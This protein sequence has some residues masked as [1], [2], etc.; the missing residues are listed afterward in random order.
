MVLKILICVCS[1]AVLLQACKS[2]EPSEAIVAFDNSLSEAYPETRKDSVTDDYFGT[3]IADPY[4]WLEDDHSEETGDWVKRQNAVTQNYL[5]KIPFR[6][7]V[8]SRVEELFNYEKSGTP[9]K[10]S[11]RYYYFRNDGLQ[12]QDVLY[13]KEQLDAEPKLVIDPNKFSEDG[14]SSMSNYSFSKDGKYL[15]FQLS[16]GG[17]DWNEI[18]VLDL[19]TNQYLS[20]TIRWVKFSSISWVENGFYYSRFPEPKAE[21]K[22]SQKNENHSVYFHKLG[23]VQDKDKLVFVD[24]KN[25]QRTAFCSVTE[26]QRILI[27]TP[28]QSTSGNEL[29]IR[30]LDKP[31]SKLKFL[32]NGFDSD[33]NVI[34]NKGNVLYVHT[35]ASADNWR[36][37]AIDLD[38]PSKE[39]WKDLVPE[40]EDVLKSVDFIGGKF[41]CTYIHNAASKAKIFDEGGS[42]V[43]ELS[44]PELGTLG[45][46]TGEQDDDE[47]F[48]SFSSFVR[49]TS[50]YRLD[51]NTYNSELVFAPV[52]KNY[53]PD[54]YTTDQ[55]W[56]YSK[57]RTKV[58]MFITYKRT[59]KLDQGNAPTLLYAYGGFNISIMPSFSS[60]RLILLEQGGIFAVPNIRGG[61]EFGKD[62][63]KAGT[64]EQKQNVFD[65]FISAAEFLVKQKYTSHDRLALE[66][67]S[68]G[69]L[70]VGA[71]ITQRPDLCRVAFPRVGV[72]DMLRYHKFTIGWAW[73]TDYGTSE[74][75]EGFDYLIRYSPLHNTRPADYPATMIATADH[76]DRVV[77]AHSFKFGAALQAAQQSSKPVLLR[78]D[79]SAGHGAGKST[80]MRIDETADLSC[81]MLFNMNIDPK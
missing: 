29:A 46:F 75:K 36:L 5:N 65:D 41:I 57:D 39:Q 27:V 1:I 28:R 56:Y 76:D 26:D 55:V 15:G 58:P 48:Y 47:A 78:I 24:Q 11:K 10:K 23:D 51:M 34:G 6:A 12:N 40:S 68:N 37:I 54:E 31:D 45:G 33:Y 44:L 72:L 18:M 4:R 9:V 22:L 60:A 2:N 77:P 7:K 30:Y 49:P 20:D 8:R 59:T 35:N 74:T 67:G 63:H 62:W 25:P 71:C 13:V 50:V 53:N 14:T 21:G 32:V 73:A 42:L 3:V 70:L 66:G 17:S 38:N 80:S 61:G 69:G 19:N 43:H 79:V 81:F 16:K 64:K 52:L